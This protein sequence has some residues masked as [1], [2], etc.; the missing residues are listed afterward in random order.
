M[1]ERLFTRSPTI[2][3]HRTAPL[4]KE[5][6]ACLVHLAGQGVSSQSLP[7]TNQ[8]AAY[9]AVTRA[10]GKWWTVD[11]RRDTRQASH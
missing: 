9:M 11:P 1:F 5:R 8:R 10:K 4:A 6:N 7:A 2:T 3:H